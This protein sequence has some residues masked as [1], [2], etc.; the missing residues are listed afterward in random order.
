[1]RVSS[2]LACIALTLLTAC[3]PHDPLDWKID[4]RNG[5]EL[6]VWLINTLPQMPAPLADEFSV[7][8]V[9]IRDN[10]RGWSTADPKATNNPLSLR[11]HR[12]TVRDILVEGL[13]LESSDYLSRIQNDQLILLRIS[14]SLEHDNLSAIERARL[15]RKL[16]AL[17]RDGGLHQHAF[18]AIEKRIKTLVGKSD[19][20]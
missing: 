4:G 11:L 20:I 2:L 6:Q 16:S 8:V 7:A 1:M 15:E 5:E 13:Q 9:R 18:D 10:T 19:P 17:R 14:Q 3:T 12:R